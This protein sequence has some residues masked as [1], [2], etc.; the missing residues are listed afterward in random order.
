MGRVVVMRVVTVKIPKEMLELLDRISIKKNVP[1]SVLIRK[2]IE[3]MLMEEGMLE[4][5]ESGKK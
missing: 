3:Q 5:E 4:K 1:R 2:A